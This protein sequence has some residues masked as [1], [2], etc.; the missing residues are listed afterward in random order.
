M[1]NICCIVGAGD[2]S[3]T[4]LSIPDGS[5][6][7][8]ADAGFAYLQSAGLTPKLIVG[9]FDSLGEVPKGDNVIA[10]N[11][12]K[13]DTDMMLA[14]KEAL[15]LNADTILIYGGLGGRI[16]HSYANLQTLA[17]IASHGAIG[18]LIGCGNVCTVIS[19]STISFDESMSGIISV[20]CM[21]SEAQGVSLS[22]LKYT[23]NNHTLT[24]DYP[25]GVSNEFVGAASL[26]SVSSGML[27][28]IWSASKLEPEKYK[29]I[30]K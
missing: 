25:L 15:K 23:L 19:N 14:V 3:G 12:E 9:D 29:W 27:A 24:C 30:K 5:D 10:H 1:S 16:D 6:I 22:G 8:A 18:Y 17:Y 7:I 21:G 20:F 11:P 4:T 13:D 2:M 26:V 28:V